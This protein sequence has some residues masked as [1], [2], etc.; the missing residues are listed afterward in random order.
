MSYKIDEAVGFNVR[1][2]RLE[3]SLTQQALAQ[4]A[5]VSKQTI[6]NIEKGTAGA[7]SRTVERIAECLG[8]SPLAL[9]REPDGMEDISFKRVSSVAGRANMDYAQEIQRILDRAADDAK[10]S[11]FNQHIQP[12]FTDF[13]AENTDNL[14][15]QVKS[16]PHGKEQGIVEIFRDDLLGS[17]RASVYDHLRDKQD[18]EDGLVE[19]G[20]VEDELVEDE[21]T[22]E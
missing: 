5:G 15:I 18:M 1:K 4:R 19:D 9:Y 3:Q 14:I 10:G 8:V 6:S 13:F 12:V 20:L 7:N 17:L 22:E 2:L 11:F 21:L 16:A